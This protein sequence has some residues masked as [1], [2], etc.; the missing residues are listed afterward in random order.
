MNHTPMNQVLGER[1]I[2]A[3]RRRCCLNLPMYW[4]TAPQG[5]SAG[6]GIPHYRVGKLVRFKPARTGSVDRSQQRRRDRARRRP[7]A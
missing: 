4:L 3:A 6:Y 5:A 1:L 2:D 7:N